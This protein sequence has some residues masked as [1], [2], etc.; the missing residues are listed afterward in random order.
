[1]PDLIEKGHLYVAQPP[2]YRL[3]D[4]KKEV[5][6]KDEE[7]FNEFI[8][9]RISEKGKV[10]IGDGEEISGKKLGHILN[11]LIKYYEN[12]SKLVKKGYSERFIEFLGS[13]GIKDKRQ[14]K[15]KIFMENLFKELQK[16][17]F[18]LGDINLEDENGYGEFTITDMTDGGQSFSVNLELLSSL[19]LQRVIELSRSMEE[20]NNSTFR[21]AA[22]GEVKEINNSRELL[23]HLME[24]GKKGISIQRY[25]GLG[26]MN[27]NQLWDT[28]MDPEK[29]TILKVRVEDVVEADEIFNILMGD[30]VEPRRDFIQRNALEV[31]ELDI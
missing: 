30:K 6:L 29:R 25:K 1:M 15:D 4:G 3:L 2:L 21:I 9:K 8:L 13:C 5:F 17:D 28:T 23:N 27:P 24:R 19:E 10:F 11:N 16:S 18:Q 14:F 22:D 31:K 26:E 12:V 7:G 20:L